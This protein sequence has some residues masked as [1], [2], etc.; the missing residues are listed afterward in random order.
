MANPGV[1]YRLAADIL[2][3]VSY[4]LLEQAVYTTLTSYVGSGGYGSGAYGGVPGATGYGYGSGPPEVVLLASNNALYV[5]AM[6]VI[7]WSL[8]T[9]EV[10][11]VLGIAPNGFVY[12]SAFANSHNPG[13]VVLGPT[14]PT[15]Q[16]TD[17]IFRQDEM[18]A[19]LARAQNEAL[20]D[21]PAYYKFTQQALTYGTIIQ[22][23]PNNCIEINR[24]AA[25]QYYCGIVSITITDNE[26]TVI[27]TSPHGL[28][29]GSSIYIQNSASGFGGVFEVDS[30]PSPTSIIYPQIAANGSTTGGAILYFSRLYETTSI[31]L[32]MT[33]RTWQNDYVG[34]PQSW[35]ESRTG[36]YQ[37]G[38]GG[39]PASN[40]QA[41]LLC[42][43]RDTDTLELLD[44]FLW[45]DEAMH[46]IKYKVLAYAFMK[47]GVQ[48][49]PTRAAYCE[50]RYKRGIMA[51]NRYLSGMGI[52]LSSG[53]RGL[54]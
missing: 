34:L 43:I 15:Q 5:G 36:L 4:H 49:D 25:S 40:F 48:Q 17:P 28:Q 13:E 39:K 50:D 1:G 24:I 18:L 41:E 16:V 42:S 52:T 23:T 45:P 33:N 27:T 21:A 32:T 7:G 31:E 6:I 38:L 3:E 20:T 35:F 51:V 19:Y 2:M 14:F 9:Q 12:M 26:T 22:P 46:I 53:G 8:S 10:V 47:D 30:V 11:T 44:G 54:A 37:W 29:V